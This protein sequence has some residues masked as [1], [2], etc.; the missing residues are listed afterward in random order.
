MNLTLRRNYDTRAHT[1]GLLQLGV[2]VFT[3]VEDAF[4]QPKI[5]GKTRIPAGTY[6]IGLRTV[7]PMASKYVTRFGDKHTGM[8]WIKGVP[9]FEFVYIH[10]GNNE[11]DTEGCVLIGRTVDPVAGFIGKSVDAYKELYP[12]VMAAHER[13]ERITIT[14]TDQFS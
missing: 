7:S 5:S 10:I 2:H 1:V 13:N 3:T 11:D 9:G 4:N 8:I 6:D 12:L 14:I